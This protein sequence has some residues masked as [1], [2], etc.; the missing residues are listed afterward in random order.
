MDKLN[1]VID[2]CITW[3]RLKKDWAYSKY[4]N[5]A[6]ILTVGTSLSRLSQDRN[7]LKGET[8]KS[9]LTDKEVKLLA[10]YREEIATLLLRWYRYKEIK[11]TLS[12]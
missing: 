8:Y 7:I 1:I 4:A 9:H 6:T 10:V 2:S 5:L 11:Q 12:S 3:G